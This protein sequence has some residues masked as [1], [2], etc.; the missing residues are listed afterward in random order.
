MQV[1]WTNGYEGSS[2]QDL[3]D[4]MGVSRGTMY[5]SFGD[6]PALFL[7]CFERYLVTVDSQ[8]KGILKK[9]GSAMDA[10][11]ETLLVVAQVV[12]EGI[13]R[14]CFVTNSAIELSPQE[15]A[16]ADRVRD[17][18]AKAHS[19]FADAIRRAIEQGE[20]KP[21]AD[22]DTLAQYLIV[23]SQGL[24]VLGKAGASREELNRVAEFTC[25]SIERAVAAPQLA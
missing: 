3:L 13:R 16:L 22:V 17:A 1:F 5:S 8:V 21:D 6:K 12:T 9:P 20:I 11:R 14:G 24:V 23:N 10:I 4:A 25:D 19:H 18:I 7:A 15:P 2:V